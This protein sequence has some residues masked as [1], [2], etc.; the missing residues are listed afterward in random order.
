VRELP[1]TKQRRSKP[2]SAKQA[3][4]RKLKAELWRLRQIEVKYFALQ[5]AIVEHT[6]LSSRIDSMQPGDMTELDNMIQEYIN[7]RVRKY[8]H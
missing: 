3:K 6:E 7:E 2:E 1:P 8:A 4:E 5:M